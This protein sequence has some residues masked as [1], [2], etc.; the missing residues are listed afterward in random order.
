MWVVGGFEAFGV[1]DD[2]VVLFAGV[3]PVLA[4]GREGGREE[5]GG[6]W[7]CW[8]WW[9]VVVRGGGGGR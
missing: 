4:L 3:S 8:W 1:E 5:E 2:L 7:G 6:W 9:A